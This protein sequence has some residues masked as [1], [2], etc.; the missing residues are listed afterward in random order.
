MS[1]LEARPFSPARYHAALLKSANPTVAA[2]CDPC[3][4][5]KAP[6][7][8]QNP[9]FSAQKSPHS[10]AEP[11][12]LAW[13]APTSNS[14]MGS[15]HALRVKIAMVSVKTAVNRG[16]IVPAQTMRAEEAVQP[17]RRIRPM[18][19]NPSLT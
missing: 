18:P 10:M 13:R 2:T 1:K 8:A 5:A 9:P 19:I 12:R 6:T 16:Q 11:P 3:S 15:A 7:I 4:R 17:L 14:A